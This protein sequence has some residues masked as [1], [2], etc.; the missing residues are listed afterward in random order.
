MA[1]SAFIIVC[2]FAP[3]MPQMN[4]K[5]TKQIRLENTF[6]VLNKDNLYLLKNNNASQIISGLKKKDVLTSP[7]AYG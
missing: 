4:S 6:L 7:T 2:M 3:L 5:G 1:F